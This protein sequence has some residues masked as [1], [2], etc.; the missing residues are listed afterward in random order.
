MTGTTGY[1]PLSDLAVYY[2]IHGAGSPLVL[3][4]GG[5]L[6]I[7]LSFGSL[8]GALAQRHQVIAIELQGHGHT[9]DRE[10]PGSIAGFAADV[11][12]VLD[13]LGVEQVDLFG[14]S[15]G[16]LVAAQ[17]GLD[18]PA[19]VGKLALAATHFHP[20]GYKPEITDPAQTS[21]LLPT[22]AD[23]AAMVT[24]YRAVA[25]DP[26]HFDKFLE[27]LQVTVHGWAGWTPEQL[28]RITAESLLIVGD[29][30]FMRL[31]HAV[32]F[33]RHLPNAQLAVL[34]RTTHMEVVR[35]VDLVLP[36]LTRFLG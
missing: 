19:R 25:P 27:K 21:D 29:N 22:E 13:H 4:H 14:Y 2:E 5:A 17:I 7:D 9:A 33:H 24:A 26:D 34:P 11:I 28:G 23:F 18:Y 10:A 3:L 6:T 20:D 35:R 31:E 1:A 8:V 36:M 32:E 12:G 30:D 16:G 15:L